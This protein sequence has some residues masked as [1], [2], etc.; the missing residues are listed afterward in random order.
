MAATTLAKD[1]KPTIVDV[2]KL[3]ASLK[4]AE[5]KY[6]RMATVAGTPTDQM[7]SSIKMFEAMRVQIEADYVVACKQITESLDSR[8]FPLTYA[9]D[10][11]G[12]RPQASVFGKM[13]REMHQNDPYGMGP[14]MADLLKTF[15]HT[16]TKYSSAQA[17]VSKLQ[18]EAQLQTM[19]IYRLVLPIELNKCTDDFFMGIAC[20]LPLMSV[21]NDSVKFIHPN[22]SVYKPGLASVYPIRKWPMDHTPMVYEFIYPI[23][24]YHSEEISKALKEHARQWMVFGKYTGDVSDIALGKQKKAKEDEETPDPPLYDEKEFEHFWEELL[25]RMRSYQQQLPGPEVKRMKDM[26]KD[27]ELNFLARAAGTIPH[28]QFIRPLTQ[29]MTR[30]LRM[31]LDR[32]SNPLYVAAFMHNAFVCIHP[33]IDENGRTARAMTTWLL[34]AFGLFPMIGRDQ[35]YLNAITDDSVTSTHTDDPKT[36]MVNVFNMLHYLVQLQRHP[37]CFTCGNQDLV[38]KCYNSNVTDEEHIKIMSARPIMYCEC[39]LVTYCSTACQVK[40]RKP[41][42]KFC[43]KNKQHKHKVVECRKLWIKQAEDMMQQKTE[44]GINIILA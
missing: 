33:R 19:Q 5:D 24:G 38:E 6:L 12:Y 27:A 14:D 34:T 32:N 36:F 11:T 9:L 21:M 13:E 25:P 30:R 29:E 4:V 43:K 42:R 23:K 10:F 40:D 41:H 39:Q 22:H 20:S 8:A 28:F 7:Q 37:F 35:A 44:L 26:F 16:I 15:V 2:T 17:Q 1:K 3:F 18:S 31:F